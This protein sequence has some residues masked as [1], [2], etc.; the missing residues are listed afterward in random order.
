[1]QHSVTLASDRYW[2]SGESTE[3][4]DH[5]SKLNSSCKIGYLKS[6]GNKK[7]KYI[8]KYTCSTLSQCTTCIYMYTDVIAESIQTSKR[9]HVPGHVSVKMASFV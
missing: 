2:Y 1:M 8:G 3:L 7:K 6:P 5:T 9:S 4:R